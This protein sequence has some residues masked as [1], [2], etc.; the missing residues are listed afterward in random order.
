MINEQFKYNID[1]VVAK[2]SHDNKFLL[3]RMKYKKL[4]IFYV[5]T[6]MVVDFAFDVGIYNYIF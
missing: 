1:V 6:K 5:K 4:K 2:F 3:L